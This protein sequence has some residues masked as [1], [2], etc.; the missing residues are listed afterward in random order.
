[1]DILG[2]N[3]ESR[4]WA[5]HFLVSSSLVTAER[6]TECFRTEHGC[7][8]W[9]AALWGRSYS[10]CFT[11]LQA[12]YCLQVC[13][14]TESISQVQQMGLPLHPPQ[15]APTRARGHPAIWP[16]SLG[17]WNCLVWANAPA[18]TGPPLPG[19]HVHRGRH[20]SDTLSKTLF[21]F[22]GSA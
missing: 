7:H 3:A 17:L 19:R 4:M 22:L 21:L 1:M 8:R 6:S 12:L 16:Y 20:S 14:N 13:L 18:V 10:C 15:L 11:F 9:P 5:S 2:T